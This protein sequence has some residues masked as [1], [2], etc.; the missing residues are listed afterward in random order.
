MYTNKLFQNHHLQ[1]FLPAIKSSQ[2]A[3]KLAELIISKIDINKTDREIFQQLQT[4]GA[5]VIHVFLD[6]GD[7]YNLLPGKNTLLSKWVDDCN[8]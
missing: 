8:E 4:L 5:R 2:G 6:S 7:T 3:E 1:I